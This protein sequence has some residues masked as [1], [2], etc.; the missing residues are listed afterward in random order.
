MSHSQSKDGVALTAGEGAGSSD[1]VEWVIRPYREG[2]LPGITA[3]IN[4][5]K[6]ADTPDEAIAEEEL[7]RNFEIPRFDPTRQAAVVEGP[8][9]DGVPPGMLLGYGRI[10]WSDDEEE[11]ERIYSPRLYVHPGARGR[12]LE[13]VIA[14]WLIDAARN[15]ESSDGMKRMR[16][17]TVDAGAREEVTYL[18]ALWQALGLKEVRQYWTMARPLDEPIDEPTQIEGISIRPYVHP[19]DDFCGPLRLPPRSGGGLAALGGRSH[20]QAG[21][22]A[23]RRDNVGTGEGSRFFPVRGAGRAEPAHRTARGVD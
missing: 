2:D 13:R 15:I 8:P 18:L 20:V 3:L 7:R 6:Q 1:G 5:A 10:A 16:K 21:A 22:F 14:G 23:A 9:V 11:Q 4:A 17:V 19:E 12:S